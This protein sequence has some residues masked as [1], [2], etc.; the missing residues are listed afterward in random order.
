MHPTWFEASRHARGRQDRF[1]PLRGG[2]RPVLTAAAR[3]APRRCRL[4]RRNGTSR[5]EKRGASCNL[6]QTYGEGAAICPKC[7][8]ERDVSVQEQTCQG[9]E[10]VG[11]AADRAPV[12]VARLRRATVAA[13]AAEEPNPLIGLYRR[14]FVAYYRV[15]TLVRTFADQA[16]IAMENARLLSEVRERQEDLRITFENMGDGVPMFD[17]TKHLI[18]WNGKFQEIFDLPDALLGQ[19]CTYE[20]LLR[21]LAPRG[22]FGADVDT[23]EQIN[24]LV[25][26]T[27]RPYGARGQMAG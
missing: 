18:A 17:E 21:F 22:D 6:R 11:N 24:E 10:A 13:T 14:R 25:A 3:V 8:S 7:G 15:S 2:L 9:D 27:G 5:T 4:R 26:S 16:V 12:R 20:E 19:G 1:A 23:A